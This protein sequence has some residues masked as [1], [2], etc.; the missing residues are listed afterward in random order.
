MLNAIVPCKVNSGGILFPDPGRK[1]PT[2]LVQQPGTQAVH[3]YRTH[4]QRIFSC[5][6]THKRSRAHRLSASVP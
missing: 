1:L 3:T 5:K 2:V 4:G 6:Y